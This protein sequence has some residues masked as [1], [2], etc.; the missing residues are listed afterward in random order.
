MND[1]QRPAGPGGAAPSS[2][3]RR[4]PGTIR[5]GRLAGAD[6]LVST[7]WFLVA[8]LIAL[9]VS[10]RIEQVEPG[11]GV[12]KYVAGFAF[13]VILYLSV[14]LHEASH[15]YV[16]RHYGHRILSVTLHFLGGMTSIDGEARTPRQEFMIAVVGPLTSLAV[17]GAAL[18]LWL[19]TPDGL[20]QIAVEGLA[21]ANLLI[22]VLNLVPGL[23]LDGGRVLKAAVWQASKDRHRATVAAAWGGRLVA[24]S[25]LLWPLFMQQVL[26]LRPQLVDYLLVFVVG[27]FLWTGATASLMQ[28]RLRRRIPGLAAVA[29]ARRALEVPEDLPLAEAVRRAQQ[30]QAGGIVTLGPDQRPA[31]I[32][33][34]SALLSTPEDRRPW[35]PVSAVARTLQQGL[36]LPYDLTGEDLVRAISSHPAEEYLLVDR[37]G[38]V[39]GVL[40]TRDVDRAFRSSAH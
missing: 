17:G 32:V 5:I 15:A 35:M 31:G 37:D 13:A 33:S 23:P 28:A 14:L 30:V 26:G 7:S 10:P 4:P 6:V 24:L 40:A 25:V 11:L 8:A 34:E 19:V 3:E 20:L 9:L 1:H 21:A 18:G 29:I 27:L 39:F 36:A 12:W 2:G 16:A 38:S 22:G